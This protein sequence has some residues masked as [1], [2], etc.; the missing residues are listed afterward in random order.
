MTEG[1]QLRSELLDFERVSFADWQIAYKAA[2][3]RQI[4]TAGN[5]HRI[6]L[7]DGGHKELPEEGY[8]ENDEEGIKFILEWVED[9]TWET[10]IWASSMHCGGFYDEEVFEEVVSKADGAFEG[11][12]Q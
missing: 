3:S 5:Q 8:F 12:S 10:L 9:P 2:S 1:L 11:D 6:E 7:L 4:E